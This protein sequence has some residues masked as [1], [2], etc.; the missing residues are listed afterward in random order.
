MKLIKYANGRSLWLM[1]KTDDSVLIKEE[2]EYGGEQINLSSCE[3]HKIYSINENP[4]PRAT[5][6]FDRLLLRIMYC[7]M[8]SMSLSSLEASA[9]DGLMPVVV[10][11]T[12]RR[13]RVIA[14]PR[15][16]GDVLVFEETLKEMRSD[17]EECPDGRTGMFFCNQRVNL[18]QDDILEVLAKMK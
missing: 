14:V 10:A 15:T 5:N 13:R 11:K 3:L 16:N 6:F 8:Y 7:Y 12:R 9:S 4:L 18:S 1:S 17:C 2:T